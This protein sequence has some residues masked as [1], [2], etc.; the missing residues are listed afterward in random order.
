MVSVIPEGYQ[1]SAVMPAASEIDRGTTV[2]DTAMGIGF[3]LGTLGLVLG[4]MNGAA[5]IVIPGAILFGSSTI[6]LA[7]IKSKS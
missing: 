2:L 5:E 4:I 7:I 6:A 1:L 3:V